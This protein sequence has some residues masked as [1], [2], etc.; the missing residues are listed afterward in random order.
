MTNFLG[1]GPVLDSLKTMRKVYIGFEGD[2]PDHLRA[3]DP[4]PLRR[5]AFLLHFIYYTFIISL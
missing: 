5:G 4:D 1:D 2:E 3:L